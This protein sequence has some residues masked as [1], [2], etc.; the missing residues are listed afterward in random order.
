[1]YKVNYRTIEYMRGI[2]KKTRE[3]RQKRPRMSLLLTFSAYVVALQICETC[4]FFLNYLY[5]DTPGPFPKMKSKVKHTFLPTRTA[6]LCILS[7]LLFFPRSCTLSIFVPADRPF[8]FV[9]IVS[10]RRSFISFA[11][12]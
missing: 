11:D 2:Y 5:L 10:V 3:V 12:F 4:I 8:L 7:P 9:N 1:M 6:F